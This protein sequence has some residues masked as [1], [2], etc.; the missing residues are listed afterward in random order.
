MA[1]LLAVFQK[2]RVLREYNEAVCEQVGITAKLKRAQKNI[3]NKEK[4]FESLFSQIDSRAKMM[5]NNA[6][7]YFQE[8]LNLGCGGLSGVMN[9]MNY[10]QGGMNGFICNYVGEALSHEGTYKNN[11]KEF[12]LNKMDEKDIKGLFSDY[13]TGQFPKDS[14]EYTNEQIAFLQNVQMGQMAQQQAQ[15]QMQQWNTRYQQDVEAWA[16]NQKTMLEC[17]KDEE[18]EPLNYEETMLEL[19]KAELEQRIEML[20]AEKESYNQ[21]CQEEARNAAP[22]FGLG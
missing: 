11:G 2:M 15:M 8:Q 6:T 14:S 16:E 10:M 22:K 5:Q 12:S 21:L 7:L 9:P 17:Q 1:L 18:L 4:W 19:D 20:K 13:M 3:K